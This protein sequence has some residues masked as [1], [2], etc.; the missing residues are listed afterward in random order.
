MVESEKDFGKCNDCARKICKKC[1][2]NYKEF[3]LCDDCYRKQC[4]DNEYYKCS[5]CGDK[6]CRECYNGDVWG[7][8]II[9]INCNDCYESEFDYVKL[10][11]EEFCNICSNDLCKQCYLIDSEQFICKQCK[12][13]Q[14]RL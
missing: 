4:D 11:R 13:Y 2:F 14:K 5:K 9:C 6:I 7:E 3:V 8:C 12:F 1:S 10:F